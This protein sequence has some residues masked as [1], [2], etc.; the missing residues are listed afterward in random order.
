MNRTNTTDPNGREQELGNREKI[1]I[2]E[3]YY[4]WRFV[5]LSHRIVGSRIQI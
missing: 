2:T 5:G 3:T 1:K 4:Y